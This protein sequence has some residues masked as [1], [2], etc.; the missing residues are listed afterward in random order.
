MSDPVQEKSGGNAA[1]SGEIPRAQR[2]FDRPFLLLILGLLV[3]V[4]FYTAW[5]LYEIVTLPE[6]SLP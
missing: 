2:F 3:M 6:S 5:G 1:E 4:V